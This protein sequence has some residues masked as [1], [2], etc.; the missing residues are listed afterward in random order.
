[1]LDLQKLL[2]KLSD[3]KINLISLVLDNIE[4]YA[5]GFR[6]SVIGGE[7]LSPVDLEK[8]F[9]LTGGVSISFK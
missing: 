9:G 8:I 7:V 3:I 6:E 1:M 4:E 5:P 2:Q